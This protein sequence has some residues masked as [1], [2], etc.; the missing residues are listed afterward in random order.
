[1]E[2]SSWDK[3]QIGIVETWA[4]KF[5]FIGL[6]QAYTS[7]GKSSGI[8]I[9][10]LKMY[11][12]KSLLIAVPSTRLKIDWEEKL[13]KANI[14]GEVVIV[15]TLIRNS[16]DVDLLIIDEVHR[17]AADTFSKTF[18]VVKYNKLLCLT[19]TT[20]RAD[21]KHEIILKYAQLMDDVTLEEGLNEGWVD[22]FEVITIPVQLTEEERIKLDKINRTYENLKKELGFGN[23]MKNADFYIKYLDI[24]KW[25][26]GKKTGKVQFLI[27]IK[28]QITAKI[29]NERFN[30]LIDKYYDRPTRTHEYFKKANAARKFFNTVAE[31]KNL[32]YNAQNKLSK[33]VELFEEYRTQYKFIFAQRI[34]FLDQLYKLLPEDEVRIYHSKIKKKDKDKAFKEF[35]DGRTK[36]KTLLSIKSLVEGTDIPKLSVS[37]ITSFTSSQVDKV[38]TWG[39]TMRKYK[40]KK[41][42][43]IY[44]Y[45]PNTQEEI[46]LNKIINNRNV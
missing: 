4:N 23:P 38:Q 17:F 7:F 33:T 16:Y 24:K 11:P 41:A 29:S 27:S 31:R 44:L 3:R 18:E 46:W 6:L 32:L 45:V 37:V 26:I 5:N 34:E 35:N 13:K 20:E 30:E 10:A 39:R 1:M 40:N 19:A 43:I 9:R 14:I 15:N 36:I 25:V 12:V 21:E 28:E 42:I 22:P 2:T 8:G